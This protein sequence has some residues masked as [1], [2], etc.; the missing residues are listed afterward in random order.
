MLGQY[1][2][3]TLVG[4]RWSR[5]AQAILV[6]LIASLASRVAAREPEAIRSGMEAR[7]PMCQGERFV[8]EQVIVKSLRTSED[9]LFVNEVPFLL[10]NQTSIVDERGRRLRPGS[11]WVGWLVELRYRTGQK[12]EVRVH[13]P[14]Q[15][16]LVRMRVLERMLERERFL[17]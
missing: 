13:G 5:L 8:E 10:T 9:R 14:E 2:E 6:I 11:L 12:S 1:R 17:E 15:K 7:S 16:V 3:C 4:R